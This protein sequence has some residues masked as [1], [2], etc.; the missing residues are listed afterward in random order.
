LEAVPVPVLEAVK[1]YV[2]E[3]VPVGLFEA[4]KVYVLEAV[5]V[6]VGVGVHGRTRAISTCLH[7]VPERRSSGFAHE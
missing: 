1:V 5:R 7:V 2:L 3:A 4:V 6:G